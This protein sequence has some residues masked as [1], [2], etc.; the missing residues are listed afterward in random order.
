MLFETPT[1]NYVSLNPHKLSRSRRPV[2]LLSQ[3][4]D[5]HSDADTILLNSS[6][7]INLFEMD[8][9]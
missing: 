1:D 2:E 7:V 5:G 6:N 8:V 4:D 3:T 9:G